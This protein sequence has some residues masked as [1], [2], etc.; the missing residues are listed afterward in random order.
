MECNNGT[1]SNGDSIVTERMMVLQNAVHKTVQE[2]IKG[3]S[4]EEFRNVIGD[5]QPLKT[6]HLLAQKLHAKFNIVF[7]NNAA[8]WLHD[9]VK[10]DNLDAKF[11]ELLVLTDNNAEHEDVE[12]WR[13]PGSVEKHLR[14]P[15]ITE[16]LRFIENLK[17]HVEETEKSVEFLKTKVIKARDQVQHQIKI[18]DE[19]T[20]AADISADNCKIVFNILTDREI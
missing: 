9:L 16:K 6:K 3:V 13:P 2:I 10:T 7:D 11:S 15:S 12:A 5:L 14:A 1:I 8:Q 20:N 4:D 18:L 19:L 17:L